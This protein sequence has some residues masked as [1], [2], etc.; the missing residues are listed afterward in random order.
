MY[1]LVFIYNK[2]IRFI[3]SNKT[4]QVGTIQKFINLN[5]KINKT[6]IFIYYLPLFFFFYLRI[7]IKKIVFGLYCIFENNCLKREFV[8]FRFIF[9]A[10]CLLYP[11]LVFVGCFGK[12]GCSIQNL[13]LATNSYNKLVSH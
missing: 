2:S 10:F 6:V 1:V 5:N 11:I 12:S 8:S 9:G 13:N 7:L 4:K 3:Y